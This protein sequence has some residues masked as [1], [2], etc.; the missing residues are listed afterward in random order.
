[1]LR[2][3]RPFFFSLEIKIHA[4]AANL[5]DRYFTIQNNQLSKEPYNTT[6]YLYSIRA[7]FVL[8]LLKLN[9]KKQIFQKATVERN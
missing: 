8:C 9:N 5:S 4:R 3:C 6:G 1:M 7:L 2:K